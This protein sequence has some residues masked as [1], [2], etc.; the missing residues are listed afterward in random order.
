MSL[1]ASCTANYN[2][3]ALQTVLPPRTYAAYEKHDLELQATKAGVPL[4]TCPKCDTTVTMDHPTMMRV[5]PCPNCWYDSCVDCREA[6]H[7]PFQCEEAKTAAQ[8][9]RL[10]VEEAIS[11][12]K[13]RNCPACKKVNKYYEN[14]CGNRSIQQRVA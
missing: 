13:I 5:L 4:V 14:L 2:P 1:D 10:T 6:S 12:A 3:S 7:I 11:A 8:Q 9:G